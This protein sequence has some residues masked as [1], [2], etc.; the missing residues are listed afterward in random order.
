MSNSFNKSERFI[1][2]VLSRFPASKSWL[3][4]KYQQANYLIYKKAYTHKSDYKITPYANNNEETFFGYYDHSPLNSSNNY[5]IYHSSGRSTKKQP[6]PDNAVSIVLCDFKSQNLI[7]SFKS[8]SYNWQQGSRLQWLNEDHF[9]FNDYDPPNDKYVSNIVCASRQEIIKTIDSPVYDCYNDY[10]LSLNFDRL[11]LLRP[12][13]GYRNRADHFDSSDLDDANDGIYYVDLEENQ[14]NLIISLEK[15]TSIKPVD[16]FKKAMHKVNH[17]MISPDGKRFMF[18]HRWLLNGRRFDRLYVSDIQGKEPVLL[19]N[20]VVSH[21]AWINDYSILGFFS[22]GNEMPLF[23]IISLLQK[24]T[25][26]APVKLLENYG[27]GHPDINGDFIVFDT[28]PNKARMKELIV[29]N[30]HQNR[31]NKLGEFFESF[32]Y[33][34]ES[35][36]DLHPRWDFHGNMVFFDSVHTG[37]RSLYSINFNHE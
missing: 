27:D 23:R 25:D 3:K 14:Y 9:I 36:C 35:R 13:Y 20:G 7:Q 2:G 15:L 30:S 26:P 16:S 21:C 11:N 4:K 19:V 29:V 37:K 33:Y 12:D 1:A 8:S 6:D 31:V 28:Y 24:D 10:A 5:L 34:D 22:K 32:D 17:I 18:L